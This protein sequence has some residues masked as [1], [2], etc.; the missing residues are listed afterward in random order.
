MRNHY[1]CAGLRRMPSEKKHFYN[2][3][4]QGSR[5]VVWH[6]VTPEPP[7]SYRTACRDD[8]ARLDIAAD[9]FGELRGQRVFFDVRVVN[10]LSQM[11][12]RLFLQACC[13]KI[14]NVK[15]RRYDERICEVEYGC[16]SPLIFSKSGGLGPVSTL[17]YKRIAQLQS[18][19][20]HKP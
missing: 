6:N 18:E 14:T 1:H 5:P 10:P 15:K 7:L 9:G 17:V 8:S 2:Y 3:C 13:K 4:K 16:F 12:W 19:K 20:F 11:Y